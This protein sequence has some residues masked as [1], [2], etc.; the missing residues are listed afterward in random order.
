[1]A[2]GKADRWNSDAQGT[3]LEGIEKQ[4]VPINGE[5]ILH[6]TVRLLKENGI[7]DIW[8]TSHNPEFE[9][10]GTTR[11]E[12]E[13]NIYEIDKLLS[14]KPIWQSP[15]MFLYGDVFYSEEA[16]KT[17][18]ETPILDR[19]LFFGR[20]HVSYYT[21]HGGELFCKKIEDLDYLEAC[22]NWVK[23]W[24]FVGKG[25]GGGWELYRRMAGVI[26]DRV[27]VHVPYDHFVGID[28]YTD[29]FDFP[30][31]YFNVKEKYENSNC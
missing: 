10:E 9:V 29:D 7:T 16:M 1:M 19:W 20:F 24:Y 23:S 21:G 4:L 28:D 6:R 13:N 18:V 5:P 2:D 8:I 11:Y 14:C 12:P 25:R 27:N 3:E 26:D 17:I 15:T 22:C 31:I 30:W